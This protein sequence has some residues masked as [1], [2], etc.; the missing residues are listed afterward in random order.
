LTQWDEANP[1]KTL[2]EF[3]EEISLASDV[4]GWK[5][6]A[7]TV[8]LMTF[9]A[10][11]GLEFN[12]VFLAGIEDGLIPS[13]QNFDEEWKLEEECRLLYVG[14]TRAMRILHCSFVNSRM[15]FGMI[16]PMEQSRFLESVPPATYRFCDE[17]F[18]FTE[19]FSPGSP[20]HRPERTTYE[21]TAS[22]FNKQEAQALSYFSQETVQFR[23]G[24]VVVHGKYGQGT[25]LAITGFGVDM[26]LTIL[27]L[28]G[29]KK[30]LMA[31]FA[32][33]KAL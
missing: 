17:S 6:D 31:K 8:N 25:I 19:G 21:K 15:R 9:H 30:N 28:D 29:S 10:A 33:L 20:K 32:N 3:L 7:G 27:F 13:K 11:K 16:M 5:Q 24:Q 26:Q 2:F 22:A 4:D 18:T 14:A 1:D 12:L 23:K